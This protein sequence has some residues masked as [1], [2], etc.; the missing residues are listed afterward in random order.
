MKSK[1]F[2]IIILSSIL[3]SSCQQE[4]VY[5]CDPV[6]NQWVKDNLNE[7]SQMTRSQW[8]ELDISYSKPVYIAF[9]PSQKHILWEEKMR[10]LF[11]FDWN[12][13]E[14]AHLELLMNLLENNE[15][16]FDEKK[17]KDNDFCAF[18]KCF[19]YNWYT[20]GKDEL[21]WSV[22]LMRSIVT[23]PHPLYNKEGSLLINIGQVAPTIATLGEPDCNC[24][25][26]SIWYA[27]CIEY[28]C[29]WT[30]LGCGFLTMFSCDGMHED[31]LYLY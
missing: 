19:E 18:I 28:N 23:D 3:L 11:K 12:E 22:D 16:L 24:N 1:L 13:K 20:Y 26:T 17:M 2:V 10:D 6:K 9:S 31:L 30:S 15:N 5:S 14:K 21:G 25:L 8:L 4:V 7:I 27:D 29:K